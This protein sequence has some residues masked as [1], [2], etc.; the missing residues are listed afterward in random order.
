MGDAV[1]DA[2]PMGPLDRG[3]RQRFRAEVIGRKN[4]PTIPAV[5]SQ[6]LGLVE[7]EDSSTRE[8]VD[9]IEHDQALTGKMLRLANSA[10]F[11]Q[12]RRVATIPR[13][14][15]L[16]GFSTVRNLALGVKVWDTVA[17]GIPAAR[18]EGLWMH[19]VMVAVASKVLGAKLCTG[20]PDEAFTA[21]LLHDV[22]RLVLATRFKDAY[23][24][25]AA[26][27]DGVRSIVDAEQEAFGVHHAE[28]GGWLLEA[29]GLPPSIVEA[30]RQHH[31]TPDRPGTTGLVA[32]ANR[33]VAV[34][35]VAERRVRPEAAGALEREVPRGVTPELW[36]AV[37]TA[38]AEDGALDKFGRVEG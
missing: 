33:L 6:V 30:A 10:F 24:T 7:R 13:A 38:L 2:R 12:S 32:M 14:V 21:G 3:G 4:L 18:L 27:A 34:T 8:L 19:A 20:D 29:W 23:W 16:L 36:Q 28:V 17:H 22:G 1:V 26:G 25:A 35:D 9:L 11:G 5:L 31:A 15:M 37:I